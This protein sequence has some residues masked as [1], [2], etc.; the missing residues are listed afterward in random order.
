MPVTLPSANRVERE[1]EVVLDANGAITAKARERSY[2]ESAANARRLFVH[3]SRP[4]Y[5]KRIERWVSATATEAT[6]SKVEPEPAKDGTEFSLSIEL[7][8]LDRSK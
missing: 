5:V 8:A 4:D 7:Q 2:G 6:V 3:H 1:A